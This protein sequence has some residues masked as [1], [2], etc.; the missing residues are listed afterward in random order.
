MHV[1]HDGWPERVARLGRD[2]VLADIGKFIASCLRRDARLRPTAGQARAA[3]I[4]LSK[5]YRDLSW[6]LP[7][8]VARTQRAS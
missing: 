1:Q 4:P 5:K 8:P 3:L 7:L 2:N 6:P